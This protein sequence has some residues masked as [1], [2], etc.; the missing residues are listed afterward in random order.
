LER[1]E[2]LEDVE[3]M[4]MVRYRRRSLFRSP[5]KELTRQE[6][7]CRRGMKGSS[8]GSVATSMERMRTER[9]ILRCVSRVPLEKEVG[10]DTYTP[11]TAMATLERVMRLLEA[12]RATVTEVRMMV[13]THRRKPM[14]ATMT[15]Q[16]TKGDWRGWRRMTSRFREATKMCRKMYTG[17]MRDWTMS[18][19]LPW[20]S[21]MGIDSRRT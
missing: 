7:V 19:C 10:W 4:V 21:G 14:R 1:L 11:K 15:V 18:V 5:S 6:T 12:G 13:T 8:K 17:E 3:S 2:P 16:E 9:Q 20:D